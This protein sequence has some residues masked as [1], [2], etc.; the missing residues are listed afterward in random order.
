MGGLK[1]FE[2]ATKTKV[3]INR[4]SDPCKISIRGT[5]EAVDEAC[6]IV[7]DLIREESDKIEES[8]DCPKSAYNIRNDRLRRIEEDTKTMIDV[9]RD[10]NPRKISIRGN[11]KESV[12][13][14]C[15]LVRDVIREESSF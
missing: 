7:R 14:A 3:Y 15:K 2:E 4:S 12:D 8:I 10:S 6:K 1:R 9:H 5:K 13:E 11:T